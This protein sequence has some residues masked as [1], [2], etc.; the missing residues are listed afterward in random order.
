MPPAEDDDLA[1]RL[2][3]IE[4]MIDDLHLRVAALERLVGAGELHPTDSATVQKKVT[5]DWQK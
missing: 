5:Y 4:R 1:N 2:S 3:R